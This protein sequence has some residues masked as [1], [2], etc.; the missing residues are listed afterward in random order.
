MSIFALGQ[1]CQGRPVLKYYVV[2]ER[3]PTKVDYVVLSVRDSPT[4]HLTMVVLSK[5]TENEMLFSFFN[6]NSC[7]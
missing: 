7:F 1:L 2:E 5:D 6:R 3:R 4:L